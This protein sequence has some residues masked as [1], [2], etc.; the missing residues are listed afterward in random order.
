MAAIEA[1]VALFSR[2]CAGL[3]CFD[4]GIVCRM[5]RVRQ[6]RYFGRSGMATLAGLVHGGCRHQFFLS[7]SNAATA[8]GA[9]TDVAAKGRVSPDCG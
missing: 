4:P 1:R 7:L 9:G 6:R 8:T 5:D 2:G 3:L